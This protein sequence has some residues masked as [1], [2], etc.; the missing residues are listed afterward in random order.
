M[1]I[2]DKYGSLSSE[3]LLDK[4][5]Q[6]G[7]GFEKYSHSCSQSTAAALHEL[8]DIDDVVVKVS[9]SLCAG[10]SGQLLGT[11]GALAGGIIVLDYFFGRPV[12][13]MSFRDES[14]ANVE[15]PESAAKITDLLVDKFVERYGTFICGQI[16]RQ[17]M[18]RIFWVKDEQEAS[19]LIA[20]GAHDAPDKCCDVVGNAAR[21]TLE[22]LMSQ[23]NV[24]Q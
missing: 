11:C 7:F 17:L 4:A 12:T 21:W 20:A 9:T 3:E 13:E 14:E 5:Y 19:K 10:S 18:G 24:T 2:R 8:V 1:R 22:I 23:F 16:Q 15:T 6:V